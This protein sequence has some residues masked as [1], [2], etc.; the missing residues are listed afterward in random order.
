MWNT[1]KYWY[2]R[3][4]H[5]NCDDYYFTGYRKLKEN[6]ISYDDSLKELF[7]GSAFGSQ[8]YNHFDF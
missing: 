5:S 1:N 3:T 6:S 7:F 2:L 8:R 4:Y